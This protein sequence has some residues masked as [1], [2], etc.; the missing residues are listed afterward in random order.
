MGSDT[1]EVTFACTKCGSDRAIVDMT[2]RFDTDE[3]ANK[4]AALNNDTLISVRTECKECGM[5]DTKEV[6]SAAT[7][8]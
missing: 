2:F 3:L 8:D 7:K 6:G 1:I 5:V 4:E